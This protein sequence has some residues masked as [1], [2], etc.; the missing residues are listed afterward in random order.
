M[1]QIGASQSP[2]TEVFGSIDAVEIGHDGR[3]YALDSQKGNIRV[4]DGRGRYMQTFGQIGVQPGQFVEPISLTS[5]ERHLF[6]GDLG[7]RVHVFS[8]RDHRVL[9]QR[10]FDVDVAVNGLCVMN[11]RVFVHGVKFG[12]VEPIHEY[13]LE[14][15]LLRSF[16]A[17]YRSK[18][19]VINYTV[20]RGHIIC[21][22]AD[23]LIVYV[24]SSVVGQVEAYDP[25]GKATW[26][27]VID[28][29]QPTDLVE[30]SNGYSVQVPKEGSHSVRTLTYVRPGE[31]ILQ[32]AYT[33][34]TSQGV[35][36]SYTRLHSFL[37]STKSGQGVYLGDSLPEVVAMDSAGFVDLQEAPFPRLSVHLTSGLPGHG[38]DG[39]QTSQ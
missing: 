31:M 33:S 37:L 8:V 32:V 4:F 15:H 13:D 26:L 27:T 6:V 17:V 30:T 7:H 2:E 12:D 9:Y 3:I 39:E 24:P 1:I 19:P 34:P 29:Y 21:D 23:G 35:G 25:D 18:T 16:G 20:S 22:K 5:D 10:T 11:G 28:G 14:G 36:A 38:R